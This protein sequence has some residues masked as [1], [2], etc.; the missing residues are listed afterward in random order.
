MVVAGC[1]AIVNAD[2]T[3]FKIDS[4]NFPDD[5][6][7][8]YV[9]AKFDSNKDG[10]LDS[11]ERN[12]QKAVELYGSGIESIEGI[13]L[14]NVSKLS[15]LRT[16]VTEIDLTDTT[17]ISVVDI[18]GCRKLTSF[19]GNFCQMRILLNDCWN[20]KTLDVTRCIYLNTLH[21]SGND[22]LTEVNILKNKYLND[23][24]IENCY[25]ITYISFNKNNRFQ[26]LYI[27]NT[28]I[29]SI[30]LTD[31]IDPKKIEHLNITFRS[32]TFFIGCS[33]DMH[34]FLEKYRSEDGT[35][36]YHVS[37]NLFLYIG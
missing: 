5:Y 7:R 32:K 19:K 36:F 11:V 28:A 15:M 30:D 37:D 31:V 24:R 16:N 25:S 13:E 8:Q 4:N 10:Y 1:G 27:K 22:K 6:F 20:L 29:Y 23:L 35:Y 33:Q 17:S 2:T 12:S 26:Y 21:I 3:K 14:L 18:S 34:N 9:S